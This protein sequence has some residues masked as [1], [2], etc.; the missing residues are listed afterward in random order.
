MATM[1]GGLVCFGDDFTVKILFL[2][3]WTCIW[4]YPP[5][6]TESLKFYWVYLKNPVMVPRSTIHKQKR[7]FF[8]LV[9]V[10]LCLPLPTP[11]FHKMMLRYLKSSSK[12]CSSSCFNSRKWWDYIGLS[13]WLRRQGRKW[14]R[15]SGRKLK[16]RELQRRRRGRRG[17]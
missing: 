2:N 4:Q 6:R 12:R 15:K 7:E 17:W 9:S 1:E 3:K 10:L 13:A 8:A 16:G 14:R 5:L 11:T